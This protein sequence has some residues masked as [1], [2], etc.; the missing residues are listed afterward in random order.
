MKNF[1]GWKFPWNFFQFY[2][3]QSDVFVARISN[4]K[5]LFMSSYKFGIA[6]CTLNQLCL[7]FKGNLSR[8]LT[9]INRAIELGAS[10]RLGPEL[11]ITGYGCEDAFY[12][13]DTV[14]HS[15]QIFG[16]ILKQNY[17]NIMICI[18]MPVI[19]DS[20]LYNCVTVIYNSKI[21][22]IRAK[23]RLAIHGNYR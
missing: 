22:Y 18:G 9:S 10:I 1:I 15:W 5:K 6:V 19:K 16:E 3:L 13:I 8:I 7:D 17:R 11:E 14:F 21:V 23:N 12:E 20:C 2:I 4:L